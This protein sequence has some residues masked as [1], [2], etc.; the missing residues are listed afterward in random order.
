MEG[1]WKEFL[2][3]F[4]NEFFKHFSEKSLEAFQEGSLEELKHLMEDLSES[5]DEFRKKFS[6]ES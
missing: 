6:V 3:Q 1:T 4:P 2:K 5:I